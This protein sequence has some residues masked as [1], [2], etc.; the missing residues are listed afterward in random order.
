MN[1]RNILNEARSGLIDITYS[2]PLLNYKE[3]KKR[4]IVF[5][6]NNPSQLVSKIISDV[7]FLAY[8]NSDEINISLSKS[9]LDSRAKFTK[10]EAKI[11]IEEKGVNVLFLALGFIKWIEDERSV[12]ESFSPCIL[13]PIRLDIDENA[14]IYI[15]KLEEDVQENFA[16]IEKFSSLGIDF[17]RIDEDNNIENYFSKLEE[18]LEFSLVK[19]IE[20]NTLVIDIFRTQKYFMYQDLNPEFWEKEISDSDKKPSDF[21]SK[22]MENN[23]FEITTDHTDEEKYDPIDVVEDPLLVKDADFSQFKA[24]IQSRKS[25]SFIIQGPPGT[26]KSQTITNLI[27][28]LVYNN[29]KILF[30][31]EKSTALEVVRDNLSKVGLENILLDLHS[32]DTRKTST[33]K[34]I[35]KTIDASLEFTESHKFDPTTYY[36]I[37]NDL[38]ILRKILNEK[39]DGSNYK[40]ETVLIKLNKIYDY[41][42]A[43]K[44]AFSEIDKLIKSK[45]DRK[46]ENQS[47]YERVL[48][49][50]EAYQNLSL[51]FSVKNRIIFTKI[52]IEKNVDI[53]EI[54]LKNL[55]EKIKNNIVNYYPLTINS[56]SSD[57]LSLSINDIYKITNLENIE[58]VLNKDII[59]SDLVNLK[60]YIYECNKI[61][62]ETLNY[63]SQIQ[64][65]T[66]VIPISELKKKFIEKKPNLIGA[67]F[68]KNNDYFK[69][70]ES[71][72]NLKIKDSRITELFR[73]LSGYQFAIENLIEKS[74]LS[75]YLKKIIINE[76]DK[77]NISNQIKKCELIIKDLEIISTK[78][79]FTLVEKSKAIEI[80]N[81]LKHLVLLK[82]NQLNNNAEILDSLSNFSSSMGVEFEALASLSKEELILISENI[83]DLINHYHDWKLF[84]DLFKSIEKENL[85]WIIENPIIQGEIIFQYWY[86]KNLKYIFDS[87]YANFNYENGYSIEEKREEFKKLDS[88]RKDYSRNLILKK[89]SL[90]VKNIFV[91]PSANFVKLNKVFKKTKNIPTVRQILANCFE[92]L[93]AIKPVFMMS[94]LSVASFVSKNLNC[95]DVVI[96]DEASQV[97]PSDAIG[98]ILRAKMAIIVGDSMQLPPTKAFDS[99]NDNH[100]DYS[101]FDDSES[102]NEEGNIRDIASILDLADSLKM[103]S[104]RLNWHYRSK[105]S[106]L[107]AVSNSEFYENSLVTFP[108]SRHPRSDE[109]LQFTHVPN[110]NYERST[111]R[112]NSNEAQVVV[113]AIILHIKNNPHLSLGVAT[114][115]TAQ[116]DAIEERLKQ[117]QSNRS[118]IDE[119]NRNHENANLFV[120]NI[121]RIQGDE[122]D[123]IFISIGYGKAVN[124]ASESINFGPLTQNGGDKRLNVLISRAKHSCH[125]FS[126]IH[127]HDIPTTNVSNL[128]VQ[129]LKIF[130]KY[131]ETKIMDVPMIT[132]ADYDSEF[133]RDVAN[134]LAKLGYAVD[135]QVGSSGFRIDLA[136]RNKDRE[137]EYLC[138]IECDGATYHRSLIARER[139]R[140][141]QE[142]LE[143]RGWRILRIWSTDWFKSKDKELE[144]IS[145]QL[146]KFAEETNVI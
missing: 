137:G 13:V 4:G 64:K 54:N 138:G 40:I 22:L 79:I 113:D 26:G 145:K 7:N 53:D 36:K 118:L 131:A 25:S 93:T 27:A 61:L 11:F 143:S 84:S 100:G 96:F 46:F 88:L 41:F 106:N 37:K 71:Y 3:T 58:K 50:L 105:F 81:S 97:K 115:S 24:I 20:K 17:P 65:E 67:I 126:S 12:S 5:S 68:G 52:K 141:R 78:N 90:A 109:G 133:E 140:I 102:G 49:I 111:T 48:K 30:V 139:D 19:S 110:G 107:I 74:K 130:L 72:F 1:L 116:M 10:N 51:S 142:I 18:L 121:E 114:F 92:E 39:I 85:N 73:V 117:N 87:K 23:F 76:R 56:K 98:A 60:N 103:P 57:L 38:I 63:E 86:F 69:F 62:N 15:S 120:K 70:K 123:V 44:I 43:N 45:S 59:F 108:D 14:K 47:E 104:F 55:A 128:G 21:I 83:D 124:S 66:W 134:S 132:G 91:N 146:I 6:A 33:L 122:R 112:K 31:S 95:F 127:Y 32:S 8:L 135:C 89:Q 2:N 129:K 80:E 94:P 144:K 125:V 9:E 34:N 75:P 101:I 28:D 119:F 29:K 42:K 136:V 99:D 35:S 82:N 77:F 16:L